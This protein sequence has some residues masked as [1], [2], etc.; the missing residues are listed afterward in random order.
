MDHRT[1]Y[2]DLFGLPRRYALDEAAL[3]ES[4]RALL[5][6][7]H[8][9]AATLSDASE[10]RKAIEDAAYANEAYRI[11]KDPVRRGDYLLQYY[12]GA[13][14]GSN[15]VLPVEFLNEQLEAREAADEAW[16]AGDHDRLE[17]LLTSLMAAQ[18]QR[19]KALAALFVDERI[20]SLE[21]LAIARQHVLSLQFLNR[22]ADDLGEKMDF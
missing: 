1:D 2:F 4:Y 8:P 21:T 3:N 6:R 19:Q 14:L 9:D 15:D 13:P 16:R 10:K 5:A 11:L 7:V 17:M 12:G 20:P 18:Q 22:F